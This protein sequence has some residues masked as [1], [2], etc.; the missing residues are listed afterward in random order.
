M[1][2]VTLCLISPSPLGANGARTIAL[3]NVHTKETLRIVYKR[4]GRYVPAALQKLNWHLR[5]WRQNKPTKMDPALI[6]L[7]WE[8]HTE[9]GSRMPV[10][11]ISGYRSPKTNSMLRKTRG[12]QARRSQH[13]LG[14]AMDVR[15]PDI[16]VRR[17]RYSALLREQ[18][19]VGYYPTS[20]TPFVHVDTGRVRH[21]PRMGRQ[22]LALLFPHGRTRHRPRG[23]GP[24]TRR[25]AVAARSRNPVLARRVAAFHDLRRSGPARAGSARTRVAAASRPVAVPPPRLVQ[26]PRVARRPAFEPAPQPLQPRVAL[27]SS[28]WQATTVRRPARPRL[29]IRPTLADAGPKPLPFRPTR[30][31]AISPADRSLLT[32]LASA[33]FGQ[34]SARR[35]GSPEVKPPNADEWISAPAYDDEHPEE[36]F[37]RPF[38]IAPYITRT[39]SFDDPA[40]RRLRH[41]DIDKTLALLVADGTDDPPLQIRPGLRTANLMWSQSFRGWPDGRP[42][43]VAYRD[44]RPALGRRIVK[45]AER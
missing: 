37:Y 4:N 6:D 29:P 16:P 7:V 25:D 41:P 5:D 44:R 17:L 43:M 12:G 23:G 19:G 36:M 33:V 15:F 2:V 24:I 8:I 10:H 9:L 13:L 42:P 40:L 31:P 26:R 32:Q 21:W 18:G 28:S 38:P 20:A 22:E 30:Q 35:P 14:R 3:Y 27:G 11:V 45:V 1:S 34:S 39:A